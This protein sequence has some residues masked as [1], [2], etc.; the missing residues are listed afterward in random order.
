MLSDFGGE[1]Q[2]TQ[3]ALCD[4][5]LVLINGSKADVDSV[6]SVY[7]RYVICRNA[8]AFSSALL[9]SKYGSMNNFFQLVCLF[10]CF[11]RLL[12]VLA[13]DCKTIC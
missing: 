6:D 13:N 1:R 8:T 5:C 2:Q 11:N 12:I 10:V 3:L 7:L 4:R 9:I